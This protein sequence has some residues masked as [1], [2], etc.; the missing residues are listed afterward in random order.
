M[1]EDIIISD[2]KPVIEKQTSGLQF[3]EGR[4]QAGFPSPA[5]GEYADTIDLNRALITNPAA[6]FC[7]RVIGNSMVDAGIN[8][9]DLL[10]IDRSLTPH[11]GNIAVCFV[12]GDFTVK[13]LS[14]RDDGIYLIPANAQFPELRVSEESNFQV[15]GVVSHIIKKL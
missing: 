6:T 11:D 9:G 1:Q 12:D 3:F 7:A 5:Q 4:V 10:I 13:R 15:W 2:V 14:V 8:E